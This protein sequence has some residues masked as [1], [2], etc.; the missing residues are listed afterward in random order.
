VKLILE[1]LKR[2]GKMN[3][4]KTKWSQEEE[5]TLIELVEKYENKGKSKQEAFEMV[6][7]IINR[8][9]SACA[10]RYQLLKKKQRISKDD[11]QEEKLENKPSITLELIIQFLKNYDNNH[12]LLEQNDK[13]QQKLRQYKKEHEELN[14]KIVNLKF[15]IQQKQ[16]VL[17]SLVK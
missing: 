15:T 2:V 14:K 7:N 10:S 1:D 13:L 16:E 5:L 8:T 3:A 12:Q 9:K 11:I 6:A 17:K 4:Q